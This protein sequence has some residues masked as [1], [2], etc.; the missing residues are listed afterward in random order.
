MYKA[1]LTS[2][3]YANTFRKRFKC[4]HAPH[5]NFDD[6]SGLE[7]L[8]NESARTFKEN[9]SKTATSYTMHYVGHLHA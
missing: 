6:F 4:F 5:F 1:H 2:T 3:T 7:Q 8:G 9:L